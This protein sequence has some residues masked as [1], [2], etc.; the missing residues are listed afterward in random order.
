MH[1]RAAA[2]G[3]V[4]DQGIGVGGEEAVGR[5]RIFP[6]NDPGDGGIGR[7]VFQQPDGE[8]ALGVFR[9]VGGLEPVH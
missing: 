6:G 3:D 7:G 5:V 1:Q 8:D 9:E 2:R 4:H